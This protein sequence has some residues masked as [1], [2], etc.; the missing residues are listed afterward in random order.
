MEESREEDIQTQRQRKTST[1][2]S[3]NGVPGNWTTTDA[4][5]RGARDRRTRID[6]YGLPLP[7]T[8][9][10]DTRKCTAH[11][12]DAHAGVAL[13]QERDDARYA[14]RGVRCTADESPAPSD[15]RGRNIASEG[16]ESGIRNVGGIGGC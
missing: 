11:L 14:G 5:V 1:G 13:E 16:A 6:D 12:R 10:F 3:G 4:D 8:A 7:V 2:S 9:P 15:S